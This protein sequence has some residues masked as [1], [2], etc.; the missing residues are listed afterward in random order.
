MVPRLIMF[1]LSLRQDWMKG[2]NPPKSMNVD[3]MTEPPVVSL[4]AGRYHQSAYK[5]RLHHQH[6]ISTEGNGV[7]SI[8]GLSSQLHDYKASYLSPQSS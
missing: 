4:C 5:V 7:D 6:Y 3:Q 8:Q 2:V 1:L